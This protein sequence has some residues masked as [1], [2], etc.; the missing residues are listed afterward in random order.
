MIQ[1]THTDRVIVPAVAVIERDGRPLVF[2]H[3]AGRAEWLYVTPG[4][5]NGRETE[6]SPSQETNLAPIQPGDTVLVE[7]HL[8]LAHDAPVRLLSRS[9]FQRKRQSARLVGIDA[10]PGAVASLTLRSARRA[11]NESARTLLDG[12]L[13]LAST[14]TEGRQD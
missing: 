8:T 6:V 9:A 7:G 11:A 10:D 1:R 2:R 5:S 12:D 3:R 14:L 13:A 4:R